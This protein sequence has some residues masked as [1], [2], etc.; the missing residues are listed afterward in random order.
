MASDKLRK[1]QLSHPKLMV[2]TEDMPIVSLYKQ[3][4]GSSI[5]VVEFEQFRM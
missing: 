4:R 5:R 1:R 2:Q 3:N